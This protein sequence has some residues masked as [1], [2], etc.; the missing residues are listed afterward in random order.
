[1]TTQT[2]QQLE[3]TLLKQLEGLGFE[4]VSIKDENDLEKNLKIQLEKF[5]ETTFS[6]REF[7]RILNYLNKGNSFEKAKNLR[8]RF[9]LKRDEDSKQEDISI[10]FFN[11]T[12]WCK[13]EYQVTNQVTQI[14]KYTNRYDVTLLINGLPL[15]QVELKRR[16]VEMKEAF[17]QIKRYHKHSFAGTLFDFIQVFIISNGVNTKYFSNNPKQG[18][19]Q[20]FYWT[21]KENNKIT[22]LEDFTEAFLEKC[23]VSQM[24]AEYVV[25]AEALKIPMILRPYQYYA[26]RA[27]EKRVQDSNKNG[28]IWHTTGSG[29]TLTSFKAAQVLSRDADI[30]KILFV[31]DRKDLDIQTTKEF[32]SF[33]D[34]SV[35]GTNHTSNLVEQLKDSNR[36]MI[37]TT[38]QKLDIAI[39]REQYLKQFKNL[40]NEKVVII[41]DECHRSQ[42]GQTHTAIKKF[43]TKAQLFGFTGTPIFAEN[44][45]GGVTTKDVFD[46]C[47]HKYII[48]NAISDNNV[49]G[50]SVEYVGKYRKKEPDVL[51]ADLE[52]EQEVEGI[53]AREVL[54]SDERLKKITEYILS[55]WKTKTKSGKFNAIFATTSVEVLKKYYLLFQDMKPKKFTV[56]TIFTYKANEEEVNDVLDA[57]IFADGDDVINEHSRDFLENCIKKYNDDFGTNHS[58]EHFYAYYK[59]V[60]EKVKTKEVDL[61]IV[62]NMMLT[63]FDSKYLNT[64]YVDKNLRYHGLIQA[65]SR[66]NRLFGPEKPHGNIVSFRNL[67]ENTDKALLLFGDEN[68]KEIV[69]KQPY[70]V[71][72]DEFNAK[73][74]KLKNI[75]PK[76]SSVDELDGE[77]DKAVFIKSFRD[78]LRVKSSL[79]TFAEFTFDDLEIDKQ[80]F[81]DYLSKYLD[82]YEERKNSGDK[83]LASI[84][85][86]IDFELELIGRD[87]VN[88]DYII[89]LIIGLKDI[90][91]DKLR[92]EKTNDVLKVMD[93]DIS[94][95]KKKDLIEKFINENLPQIDKKDDV[96]NEF[97]VFWDKEKRNRMTEIIIEEGID[98]DKFEKIIGEYLYTDRLPRR[99]EILGLKKKVKLTERTTVFESIK[100]KIVDFI[101]KFE[102]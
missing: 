23:A 97:E 10:Q 58:T 85:D 90:S 54:E 98:A 73:L 26:V 17:N 81:S 46:K 37:V 38:I 25:L 31:V 5:N 75:A 28:Y 24:I 89:K 50:F 93:R 39:K 59:D 19:E 14:G 62:V 45:I 71:Q 48:T 88:Y 64:L 102:W 8:D 65:Y 41:F 4:R 7:E 70:E 69:F 27:I 86:E 52:V 29:K 40:A 83:D 92:E 57:D 53:N 42:F 76:I 87:K 36:K 66:T 30:K 60:Q 35:D 34:G 32:N 11:M 3:N 2:E 13:N 68:A 84:L 22:K 79:Q 63:G 51:E 95:R 78:L 15:V 82:L 67:K 72:K 101:E 99:D 61:V 18:Y 12:E 49:L 80:E 9:F 96:E 100:N 43:F 20:T 21:D 1:M 6:E 94:L 74:E 77:E 55:D 44:N 47:L 16:G 56:A 91:S 33:S